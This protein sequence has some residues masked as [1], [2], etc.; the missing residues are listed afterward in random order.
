MSSRKR[1]SPPAVAGGAGGL[2]AGTLGPT[3]LADAAGVAVADA[4]G[5]KLGCS[6]TATDGAG[7][8]VT[9]G[10]DVVTTGEGV[11]TDGP[12]DGAR[13]GPVTDTQPVTTAIVATDAQSP[14]NN[15]CLPKSKIHSAPA[16]A[17]HKRLAN[18]NDAMWRPP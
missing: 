7:L 11:A 1:R 2:T 16:A 9:T 12:P 6:D 18:A 3:G 4:C 15:D 5:E 8:E 14:L 13:D 17:R 10:R